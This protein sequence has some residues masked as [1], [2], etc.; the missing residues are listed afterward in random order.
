MAELRKGDG[1]E[2]ALKCACSVI[3]GDESQEGED[4]C[5]WRTKVRVCS[6]RLQLCRSFLLLTRLKDMTTDEWMLPLGHHSE[7]SAL[8]WGGKSTANTPPQLVKVVW[9]PVRHSRP[10]CFRSRR[11][12]CW[13]VPCSSPVTLSILNTQR[14][15]PSQHPSGCQIWD[16]RISNLDV[17]SD[18]SR[19]KQEKQ[20]GP[21]KPRSG[22]RATSNYL[23]DPAS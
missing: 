8:C 11:H 5:V 14:A 1:I 6:I 3:N 10:A 4:L 7:V 9:T 18:Q 12:S 21:Q 22:L 17:T 23:C 2:R 16:H 19:W 13:N 20:V 15:T